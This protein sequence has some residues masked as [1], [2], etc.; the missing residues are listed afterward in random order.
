MRKSIVACVALLLAAASVGK[1]QENR[2]AE[3]S[4]WA[5]G[6]LSTLNYS[7]SLGSIGLGYGAI[8][9]VGYATFFNPTIG[10]KFGL[11]VMSFNG[12]VKKSNFTTQYIII[13]PDRTINSDTSF[14]VDFYGFEEKQKALYLNVPVMAQYQRGVFYASL[15]A[16]FGLKLSSTFSNSA[17]SIATGIQVA[18]YGVTPAYYGLNTYENT[19]ASGNI[20]LGI[21]VAVSAEVGVVWPLSSKLNL[22]TGIYAD[23]GLTNLISVSNPA[24][25]Y[26]PA[27]TRNTFDQSILETKKEITPQQASNFVDRVNTVSVGVKIA[28]GIPSGGS[29]SKSKSAEE[30]AYQELASASQPVA[31]ASTSEAKIVDQNVVKEENTASDEI[32]RRKAEQKEADRLEEQRKEE[33]KAAQKQ[34]EQAEKE[35]VAKEKRATKDKAKMSPHEQAMEE[36]MTQIREMQ[37]SLTAQTEAATEVQRATTQA[38]IAAQSAAETAQAAAQAALVAV[39]AIQQ[40]KQPARTQAVKK[41]AIKLQEKSTPKRTSAANSARGLVYKV[42]V[43]ARVAPIADMESEFAAYSFTYQVEEELYGNIPSEY[44]YKY[45]TGAFTRLDDAVKELQHIRKNGIDDAFIAPYYNGDRI[46]MGEANEIAAKQ[47]K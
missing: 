36:N 19:K 18:G 5:G 20:S 17:D 15:G 38:V 7:K 11:E 16:K 46:T 6:G 10:F 28:V 43:S 47:K 44:I 26:D 29:S 24:M 32:A 4:A 25:S 8:G 45:V 9:G 21:N 37:A 12:Q 1:A 40:G 42:Q 13:N 23:Y 35:R 30:D 14:A 22:Y 2:N 3:F 34:A 31:S 41:T 33:D 27:R 39:E